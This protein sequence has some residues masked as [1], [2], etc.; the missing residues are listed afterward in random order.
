MARRRRNPIPVLL[1]LSALPAI[2]LGAAWRYA[3]GKAPDAVTVEPGDSLPTQLPTAL[4]APLLSLR[5][6]PATLARDV[7]ADSFRQALQ[8]VLQRIDDTSCL[9]VAVDGREVMS[10]N[11]DVPLRP[12]SNVKLITAAVALEVLGADHRFTTTVRAAVESGGVVAGDLYLVGG[13]DPVLSST[14][15]GTQTR[16]PPFNVTPIEQLADSVVAAGVTA[17]T[18]SVVG[19]AS[20]F[21]GEWYAPTWA[22]GDRFSEGGPVSALL[23]NDSREAIDRSSNDP[24]VG[25]AQVFTDLL[26]Q[27]GVTVAG[28][29]GEGTAPDI[30]VVA[31]IDS[32]PLPAILAEML[33][34]SDNNTAEL[35]LKEIGLV[36]GEGGTRQDGLAVVLDRLQR[37]GVPLDGVVLVDGSGLSD[38]NRVTCA[39]L[40]ATLQHGAVDDAVGAGLAVAGRAGGTLDDAFVD[41]PMTDRLRAKTGTLYNYDGVPDKPGV[42]ALTGYVPIEGGG[43]IEFS[44]LLN[45]EMIGEKVNYS[46][47]WDALAAAF[48]SYPAGPSAKVLGPGSTS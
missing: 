28:P 36:G 6:A 9:S 27:R 22:A 41:T 23:A 13:G 17:V 25:A 4:A 33:T 45:G 40:M 26:R 12:A 30:G 24:V 32:Q 48:G 35:V 11:A 10:K 46:P 5:R 3:E 16:Y 44:M 37:W 1:V 21:D 19:D 38:E 43:A 8:P 20:R 15:W 42:K 14:W 29:P 47:T 34:T 39:T 31:S 18:G 7:N 2:G